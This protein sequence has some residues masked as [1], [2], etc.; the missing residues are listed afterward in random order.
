[1]I[2]VRWLYLL[3]ILIVYHYV[4]FV[5]GR[6]WNVSHVRKEM[7]INR[8]KHIQTFNKILAH[9]GPPEQLQCVLG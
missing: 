6:S 4:T 2:A 5:F 8:M 3:H 1:M 9:R 7:E